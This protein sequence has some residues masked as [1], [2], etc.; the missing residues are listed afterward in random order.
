MS[1]QHLEDRGSF[2]PEEVRGKEP[3]A[4]LS[5]TVTV[6]FGIAS[7]GACALMVIG[8]GAGLSWIGAGAFLLLLWL[9][10]FLADRGIDRQSDR[11]EEWL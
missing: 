8:D 6:A 4:S 7:L 1:T 5:A 2:V 9:F 10:T 11:V 3:K